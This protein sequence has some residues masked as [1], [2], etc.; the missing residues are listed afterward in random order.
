MRIALDAMGG[1]QAPGEIILG[2]ILA[3][4]SFENIEILLVGDQQK[5]NTEIKKA[6]FELQ[7]SK[8]K[9]WHASEVINMEEHPAVAVKKKKD[10]SLVVANRLVKEGKADVV[11]SAGNTGAAMTASLL[12]LGR[13]K[14]INRP[15][16]A[17][18]MPNL[19]GVGVLLDAGANA[20]CDPENLVKFGIMGSIYAEQV[21]EITNPRVGLLS[22]GEESTKGNKLVIAAHELLAKTDL[23]FI[24]NI[25]GR[26]INKG[27][28][29]VIVCDGFVGNVVLKMAEGLSSALFT[30]IKEAINTS[31]KSK[32]GGYLLRDS[33]KILKASLDHTEYGGAPL[34]GLNGL[35]MI[36]HG[37]SNA[38]AI[39][40]A[41]KAAI[42]AINQEVT[43]KIMKYVAEV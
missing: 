28:C 31:L 35:S 22:I 43:G 18:L 41:I 2:A 15:A 9:V 3:S 4:R 14:G 26:D 39:K 42:K 12:T 36:C 11:I 23:N 13:V 10:S 5:L 30:Q 32:M 19:K 7:G 27:V 33:F 1:D 17:S 24:G 6:E 34:L 38:K 37:S 16:I 40:N 29:D 21:L 8:L 25:E 20:D